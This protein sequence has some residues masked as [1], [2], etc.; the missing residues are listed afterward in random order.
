MQVQRKDVIE[1]GKPN[2]AEQLRPDKS[3]IIDDTV[4]G[5]A[6]LP[7]RLFLRTPPSQ[8]AFLAGAQERP[9]GLQR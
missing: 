6:A 9:A 5:I 4:E 3:D 1:I 8:A 2:L 7:M